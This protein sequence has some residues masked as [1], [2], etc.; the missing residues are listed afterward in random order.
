M[1]EIDELSV[2][3][4]A[5]TNEAVASITKLIGTLGKLSDSLNISG[6]DGFVG[7]M[8]RIVNALDTINTENLDKLAL[9]VK[10]L[11]KYSKKLSNVGTGAKQAGDAV[12]KLGKEL[13][14]DLGITDKNAI[15][16]LQKSLHEFYSSKDN[17]SMNRAYDNIMRIAR[18]YM[19]I[20]GTANEA[21]REAQAF[22]DALKGRKINLPQEW[23]KEYGDVGEGRRYR[24]MIGPLKQTPRSGGSDADDVAKELGITEYNNAQDAFQKIAQKAAESR[25]EVQKADN[26]MLSYADALREGGTAANEAN[27]ALE[28]LTQKMANFVKM[29]PDSMS[30]AMSPAY[31]TTPVKDLEEQKAAL[32]QFATMSETMRGVGNPFENVTYGL[33]ELSSIQLS[34]TLAN[35]TYI[36]DAVSKVGGESGMRAGAAMRDIASGLQALDVPV[37]AIGEELGTLA[38]GLRALGSGNVVT[39]SQTLPFLSEGL[40]E[41]NAV[42][43]T[44]DVA[45]IAELANAVKQFGYAKVE[46]SIANLPVLASELRKLIEVLAEAPVVSNNTVELVKALGQLNVNAKQLVPNTNRAGKALNLFSGHAK[47]AQ[48]SA[49]SLAAAIGKVYATYWALF[50]V[51]GMF[52]SSID[53]ASDLTEV[54]NVVDH[55][56]GQMKDRM[57]DFAKSAV[58]TV[59]MSELTAKK[60]GSRFQSMGRNMGIPNELIVK[61]GQYVNEATNGY[62]KVA[63]SMADVSINLT[64]LAGD[65]ASFYNVE[66]ADVAEDLEATFTGMTRPLRKYG[67]D[68]TVATM[69]EYALSRGLNADIKNMTQA[70]KTMLRYQYIMENTTAAHGDFERTIGTWANQI[71]LAQENLKRLQ[72]ILGQI[73]IYTFKPLVVNFNAAMNDILHLAE[74][75]FNALGT[76]FGWQIEISDVGV[77]DDM[78]DGLEDVEDGYDDAADSAKKFKNMLLG[79]DELNLLP[80]NSDKGKGSGDDAIGAMANGLQ[81]SAVNFKKT[82]GMFDSL[83]DT[84]FK[85]GA[86]IGEVEKEWLK[87]IDWDSVYEKARSF[88]KGLADFLNGYFSDAELFYEKGKFIANGINT[89][90]NAIDEFFKRFNGWQFG[91]DIGNLINGFTENLDWPTIRSAAEGM[92]EDIAQTINGALLT[93]RWDDV[94]STIANAFNTA[95]DFLYTLGDEISWGVVG[96]AIAEGI[97]GLFEDFDFVKLAATLNKWAKGLLDALIKALKKTNWKMVGRKIGEFIS[98]IDVIDIAG[99]IA[100]VLWE[101]INA[102]VKLWVGLFDGAPIE[103]A[104]ATA[105]AIPFS[106][107]MFRQNFG[108]AIS[109]FSKNIGTVLFNDLSKV[110]NGTLSKNFKNAFNATLFGSSS[111]MFDGWLDTNVLQATADGFNAVS[112][113]LS[114]ITKTLGTATT[115]IAEFVVV[116]D[117]AY[118]LAKGSDTLAGSIAQLGIS[119]GVAAGA[120]SLLLGVPAGI[121]VAGTAAV[122]AAAA[123]IDKA[124]DEIQQQNV[125]STLAKDMDD[126]YS[127]LA[128]INTS[129]NGI[130]E[131][132]TSGIDKL[133]K[134]HGE[135]SG[136]RDTLGELVDNFVVVGQSASE[137]NRLTVDALKELVGNIDEVKEAW[138][139]YINAQYDYMIQ[140]TVN[141]MKFIMSQRELTEEENQY[142]IDSINKLTEAKY[143]DMEASQELA[144]KADDAWKAYFDAVNSGVYSTSVLDDLYDKATEASNA[145]YGLAAATGAISDERIKNVNNS[146]LSLQDVTAK[147]DFS[148]IDTSD[149]ES[150]LAE[151]QGYT[152]AFAQTY[153]NTL[154]DINSYRN[155]LLSEG[156]DYEDVVKQTQEMYDTLDRSAK[157]ALDSVQLS[158]YDKLYKFIGKNDY[159]GA[160]DFYNNV[161]VPYTD[162][163]KEQYGK[164]T[165]GLEPWLAENSKKML[166]AAFDVTF[167]RNEVTG[168]THIHSQLVE[169]W[170]AVFWDLRDSVLPYAE[171]AGEVTGNAFADGVRISS[172]NVDSA[173][174]DITG[175]FNVLGNNMNIFGKNTSN[176]FDQ[177]SRSAQ[178]FGKT[179]SYSFG[180]VTRSM[181]LMNQNSSSIKEG[182]SR[183]KDEFDKTTQK[184]NSMKGSLDTLSSSFGTAKD[185]INNIKTFDGVKKSTDEV[186]TG[187]DKIKNVSKEVAGVLATNLGLMSDEFKTMF[188][189][190]TS[191][192]DIFIGQFQTDLTTL[193]SADSWKGMLTGIP[194]TFRSMWEDTIRVMKTMWAEF[195]QWVNTNAVIE[196]PKTKIGNTEIGGKDVRLKVP[197]FDIGGSIPNNGSLFIANE[198]GPEVMANMGSSTGIMNTDQMEAA[199][200]NGMMRALANSGQTVQVVLNGDAATFFT[201]MVKENNSSIMRTGASPLRV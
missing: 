11:E 97:N 87:G 108:S 176:I 61:T 186:V 110:F 15:S 33:Q 46:K 25:E 52:K 92:A 201:A 167:S 133:S 34:D 76:I 179:T 163:I 182:I 180:N 32:G 155:D 21:K 156:M 19:Q 88:A 22:L 99:K 138:K 130:A 114:P 94:G 132:I 115:V 1:A 127:T 154:E 2:K 79:I 96:D 169:G 68:L 124:L 83:Y 8:E 168:N 117:A 39:A 177:S 55:T 51:M 37:P 184:A 47:K 56:F 152:D 200:T 183:I 24:T 122:L 106:N 86:R 123:G 69:K 125:L 185:K 111:D 142:F 188:T 194:N 5:S 31:S 153:E 144:Q 89:V 36:K 119:A 126:T 189:A 91:V 75:T 171:D 198:S 70:E 191:E 40:R 159:E 120:L 84:L 57:E 181:Q 178:N 28:I 71:K 116:K 60:I 9:S 26:V 35:L 63:D 7:S 12:S 199:I 78:A 103:T 196:I 148:N 187:F 49:F 102:A 93:T 161:M 118:D 160:L 100:T 82:E 17:Q 44:T 101:A 85:L 150:A 77:L 166:D 42:N 23:T 107:R 66:Y 81:E 20:E 58:E 73:G 162:M 145:L 157:N 105:I 164:A 90:A 16:Q 172:T 131:D 10:G 4:T 174:K 147:I 141:N 128:D 29:T 80:D 30:K 53:L 98:N 41:L 192:T 195:A 197:R 95:V 59:G 173:V 45:K 175:S 54:Q 3:I 134:A 151:I 109:T 6:I 62:G 139:N 146:L 135:L 65:M 50:R 14:S 129:F 112:A 64:R 158:L 149:Y 67:L 74:S 140:A 38:N 43:I 170:Q 136:L 165:D 190:V 121:I 13:A 137:G 104:L 27:A 193:F 143:R 48:K 113:S 18:G 72:V